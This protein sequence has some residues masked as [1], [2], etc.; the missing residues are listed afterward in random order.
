MK[1]V[2]IAAALTVGLWS[3][4]APAQTAPPAQTAQPAQPAQPAPTAQPVPP[5]QPG[6]IVSAS[7]AELSSQAAE[8]LVR[9]RAADALPLAEKALTV[10][11]RNP[12]AHYNRAAALADMGRVDQAI[13][14]YRAAEAAFTSADPWGRSIS[15]YGRANALAQAGRCAEA[16]PAYEEY[17]DLVGNSDPHSA[18]LA[19]RYA[20]ECRP[21]PR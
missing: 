7:S 16:R 5:R 13:A 21:R 6:E 14:E 8:A 1:R 18:A 19:R 15:I 20:Q 17:A 2:W 10:D 12:W 4:N 11:A 9:G 3:G